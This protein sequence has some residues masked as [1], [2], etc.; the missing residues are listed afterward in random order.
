MCTRHYINCMMVTHGEQ[1]HLKNKG[2]I[3]PKTYEIVQNDEKKRNINIWLL[4]QL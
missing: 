4:L 3:D 2:L 1:M